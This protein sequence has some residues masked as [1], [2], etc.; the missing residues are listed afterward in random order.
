M[1]EIIKGYICANLTKDSA[2]D[3][4]NFFTKRKLECQPELHTTIIH[5]SELTFNPLDE[6]HIKRL[7]AKGVIYGKVIGG[8]IL[9]EK[10][11][12]TRTPALVISSPVIETI[13]DYL[14]KNGYHHYYDEGIEV[15]IIKPKEE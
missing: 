12:K 2:S 10:D 4:Y 11:S 3:I 15:D 9:G 14:V 1:S 6:N 5:D 13:H 7:A 8:K